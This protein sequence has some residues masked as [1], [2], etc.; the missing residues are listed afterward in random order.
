MLD[1]SNI[2]QEEMT[3]NPQAVLDVLE[4]YTE[5]LKNREDEEEEELNIP[6]LALE[7]PVIPPRSE[8]SGVPSIK[9]TSSSTSLNNNTPKVCLVI[10]VPV[11]FIMAGPASP[12]KRGN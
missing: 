1:S 11:D 5:N 10:P 3:K 12:S 6:A 8:K 7:G 9:A 2:S 4:F